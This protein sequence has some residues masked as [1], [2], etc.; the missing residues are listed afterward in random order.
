MTPQPAVL[1]PPIRLFRRH[2]ILRP[3]IATPTSETIRSIML[4][5]TDTPSSCLFLLR[6]RFVPVRV[7]QWQ[8]LM[9]QTGQLFGPPPG[10][11]RSKALLLRVVPWLV[12]LPWVEL[13][14]VDW[15]EV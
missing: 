8:Q 12:A 9:E 13:L 11:E 14:L 10:K 6:P 5:R 4:T 7:R 15:V 3:S 2:P 1:S